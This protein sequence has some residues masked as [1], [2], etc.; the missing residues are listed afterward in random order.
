MCI[1]DSIIY[2]ISSLN[3][4]K[5]LIFLPDVLI[6]YC[7]VEKTLLCRKG[8]RIH[9]ILSI[10]LISSKHQIRIQKTTGSRIHIKELGSSL[11]YWISNWSYVDCERETICNLEASVDDTYEKLEARLLENDFM[12]PCPRLIPKS[13]T[14]NSFY[15]TSKY[16]FRC[17]VVSCEATFC[18]KANNRAIC[19]FATTFFACRWT[20]MFNYGTS[21]HCVFVGAVHLPQQ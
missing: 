3:S 1:E 18:S 10:K 16:C 11:S 9:S 5:Y 20:E 17:H 19:A 13:I 21:Q 2:D 7:Q 4:V 15:S 6:K 14:G 12:S 8:G